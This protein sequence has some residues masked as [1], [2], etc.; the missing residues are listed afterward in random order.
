MS[1]EDYVS[2]VKISV[3]ISP[4]SRATKNLWLTTFGHIWAY[5]F[6]KVSVGVKS[7]MRVRFGNLSLRVRGQKRGLFL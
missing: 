1:C 2:V 5:L 7:G 6:E 4:V 3:A